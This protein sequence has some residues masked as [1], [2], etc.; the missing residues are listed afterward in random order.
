MGQWKRRGEI[1]RMEGREGDGGRWM[2][3]KEG[4]ERDG[5]KMEGKRKGLGLG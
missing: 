5:R 3:L 4:G 1:S 2:G